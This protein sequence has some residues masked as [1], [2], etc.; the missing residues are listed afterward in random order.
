MVHVSGQIPP[1]NGRLYPMITDDRR[2]SVQGAK[3]SQVLVKTLKP[4]LLPRV[5]AQPFMQL[6]TPKEKIL[7]FQ[8]CLPLNNYIR[9]IDGS[10]GLSHLDGRQHRWAISREVPCIRS[11][12][13]YFLPSL[14]AAVAV[15]AAAA[16]TAATRLSVSV[17]Q[18]KINMRTVWTGIKIYVNRYE[19]A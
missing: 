17:N 8:A 16:A 7:P 18:Q 12:P 5:E 14:P 9:Q 3:G 10:K 13:S 19:P 1:T 11:F 15:T 6:R 2:W 4:T